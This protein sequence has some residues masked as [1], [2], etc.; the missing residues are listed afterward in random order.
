M[1]T[2][3][4]SL[5][6]LSDSAL[7]IGTYAHSW[8]LETFVQRGAIKDRAS[9]TTAIRDLLLNSVGPTDAASCGLAYVAAQHNDSKLY[10]DLAE[11]LI[12]SRWASE[13]HEA[14]LS[15]GKRL[16][17]LA[18]ESGLLTDL[19]QMPPSDAYHCLVFGWL[20][21]KLGVERSDAVT[22]YLYSSAN[23]MVSAL[24]RLIPL[25][26]TDGQRIL[27]EL[28]PEIAAMSVRFIIEKPES[29]HCFAPMTDLASVQHE[30]LYSRL[31]QS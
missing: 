12:A 28:K 9:A 11:Q 21:N 16:R 15:T 14:A 30:Q 8:G 10:F 1:S 18:L 20:A 29:L 6:Q 7:P 27:N 4:L 19:S 5:I 24:V 3:L 17:K 13:L 23:A 26:H 31:F 22:A 25:G 2:E